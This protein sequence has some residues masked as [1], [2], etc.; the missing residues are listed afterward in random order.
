[1]TKRTYAAS[2]GTVS[3]IDELNKF[4]DYDRVDFVCEKCKMFRQNTF[5]ILK[6][7]KN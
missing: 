2:C 7:H 1:M 4:D 3:S 5:I 6:K